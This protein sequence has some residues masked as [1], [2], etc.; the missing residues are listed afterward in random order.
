MT[1]GGVLARARG[2]FILSMGNEHNKYARSD[3]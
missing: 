3:S 2:I 1:M